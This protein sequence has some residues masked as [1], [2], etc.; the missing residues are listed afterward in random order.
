MAEVLRPVLQVADARHVPDGSGLSSAPEQRYR[1]DLSDGVHLQP[2][3]LAASLNHLVRDGA[4]RRGSVVHILDF[5]CDYRR[6]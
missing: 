1:L 5:N 6:R 3:T 2:G 4:L